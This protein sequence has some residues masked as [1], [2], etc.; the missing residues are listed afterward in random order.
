MPDLGKSLL[1]IGAV[2]AAIGALL[3]LS[4]KM[5]WLGRLPG[6]I[7]IRRENFSFSFP[8][9]TCILLSAVISL[10]LWLLRK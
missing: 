7:Y 9:T 1:I 2:I 5:P 6:D 8:L 3:M 4:G 10:I